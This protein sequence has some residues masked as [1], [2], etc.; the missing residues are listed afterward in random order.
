MF[1]VQHFDMP[2]ENEE[3][4]V[5]FYEHIF[6][7]KIKSL[8]VGDMTYHMIQTGSVDENGR[9]NEP[10]VIG[11]GIYKRSGPEDNLAIYVTVDSIEETIK[12]VEEHGGKQ[13]MPKMPTGDMGFMAKI[14]DPDGNVIGLW[15]EKK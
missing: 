11:G 8:P 3:Q 15:E 10:N 5:H 9:G 4:A 1:K 13:V 2:A 12:Q 7:W 6:G 14:Q